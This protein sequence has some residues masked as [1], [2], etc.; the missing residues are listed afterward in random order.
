MLRPR[1]S[2]GSRQLIEQI[3]PALGAKLQL[4]QASMSRLFPD[5]SF[6]PP[7]QTSHKGPTLAPRPLATKWTSLD[8]LWVMARGICGTLS[9]SVHHPRL[10]LPHSFLALSVGVYPLPSRTRAF[11]H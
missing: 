8:L 7:P 3:R 5:F 10:S 6:P 4:L 9:P 1:R 11:D 2:D